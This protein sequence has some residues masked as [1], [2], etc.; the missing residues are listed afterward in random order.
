MRIS[1]KVESSPVAIDRTVYFGAT[2]GRLFA[3]AT[4]TGRIK[5][6]YQTGG[7]IN[8]SPSVFGNR[9]CITTYAGSILC[10][11][12][13]T[14]RRLWITYVKRD[15]LRYESFYA[16]ASTD[17]TRL[18]TLSR[19][20]K[21][22]ALEAT[23]GDVLWTHNLSTTGYSTPAISARPRLRRRLQ[24]DRP[25]LLR[26]AGG[27]CGSTMSAAGSSG[28]RSSSAARLRL[29]A[30]AEDVRTALR[31]RPAGVADRDGQVW[32]RDRDRPAL[33]LLAERDPRVVPRPLQPA[34]GAPQESGGCRRRQSGDR[35]K[36]E[37]EAV[38]AATRA[39][40]DDR[41]IR[42]LSVSTPAAS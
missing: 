33:L 22:V 40:Y 4:A 23:N 36:A 18:F 5:W 28:L 13:R 42:P 37:L 8:S 15:L 7:R 41:A 14:G 16:S 6:A 9:V 12:R 35:R 32:P 2:D 17:G 10:L 21:V 29:D 24:R 3:L 38:Q 19:S 20:G 27:R 11:D 1:A 39:A 30:G 31:R 34:G 25:L 26:G